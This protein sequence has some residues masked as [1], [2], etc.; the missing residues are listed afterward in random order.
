MGIYGEVDQ[1]MRPAVFLDRDG[2]INRVTLRRNRPYPPSSLKELK[3][4]PGVKDALERLKKAGYY[5]CVVTNQPDVARKSLSRAEVDEIN[6][7]LKATL[8]LDEISV[9]FHDDEDRCLCRKPAP[10]LLLSAAKN[11]NLN[12]DES[13]MIGDRWRDIDAG[14]A[15][16][17]KTFFIDYGYDERTPTNYTYKV[18]SLVEAVN[19]ILG[20][21]K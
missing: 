8:A 11:N 6:A 4:L 3:V 14:I 2:V 1:L 9:C 20:K 19:I 16:G 12:L 5:L 7:F 21:L 10:G 17:C 15:A 18:K 13:F